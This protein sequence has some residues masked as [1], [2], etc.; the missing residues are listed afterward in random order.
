MQAMI[1]EPIVSEADKS[2]LGMLFPTV[3]GYE[4]VGIKAVLGNLQN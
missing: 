2:P 1:R 4:S 3:L